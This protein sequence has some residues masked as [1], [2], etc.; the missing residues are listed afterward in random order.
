MLFEMLI[1]TEHSYCCAVILMASYCNTI[2]RHMQCNDIQYINFKHVLTLNLMPATQ[3][4]KGN[5]YHGVGFS[6]S[7][8]Q[9]AVKTL[10]V[11]VLKV[12]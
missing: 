4:K 11:E 1:K 7:S 10:I 12:E 9:S 3:V 5:F 2:Q 6:F 8:P